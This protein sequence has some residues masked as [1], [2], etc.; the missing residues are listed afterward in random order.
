MF[1]VVGAAL[2]VVAG[3]VYNG[4]V[5]VAPPRLIEVY[6]PAR[7]VVMGED[8]G[9]GAGSE[10]GSVAGSEDEPVAGGVV[11][12]LPFPMPTSLH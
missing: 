4:V 2:E 9:G 8:A 10:E 1:L 11:F 5:V 3:R 12:A 6:V 7:G